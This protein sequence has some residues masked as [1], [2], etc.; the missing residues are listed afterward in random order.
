[1]PKTYNQ[2]YNLF[3]NDCTIFSLNQILKLQY[4]VDIKYSL[5]DRVVDLALKVWVLLKWGAVFSTIYNWYANK[6]SKTLDINLIVKKKTLSTTWFEQAI[7]NWEF[8]WLYL[9]NWNK[10]YLDAVDRWILTREVIDEMVAM[11]GWFKHNNVY[12]KDTIY[13]VAKWK[14]LQCSL[15]VIRYGQRRWVFWSIWRT[16]VWWD[17]FTKDVWILL[18]LWRDDKSY[19]PIKNWKTSDYDKKVMHKSA[20]IILNYEIK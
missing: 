20:D 9:I 11:W 4:W 18:K 8:F 17:K 15:D 14:E 16:L 2:N 19:D 13:E 12:W 1:M 6:I 3:K 5:I 7:N 10:A